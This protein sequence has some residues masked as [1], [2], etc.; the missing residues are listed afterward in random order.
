MALEAAKDGYLVAR[1]QSLNIRENATLDV[2]LCLMPPRNA[3]GAAAGALQ[4]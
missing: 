2:S 3:E 4:R 1:L